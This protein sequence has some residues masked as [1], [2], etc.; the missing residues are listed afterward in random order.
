MDLRAAQ[1]HVPHPALRGWPPAGDTQRTQPLTPVR[2]THPGGRPRAGIRS[3]DGLQAIGHHFPHTLDLPGLAD[4]ISRS[5]SLATVPDSETTPSLVSTLMSM[6]GVASS[7]SRADFTLVVIQVS[8]TASPASSMVDSPAAS[9][10][11]LVRLSSAHAEAAPKPRAR[12][13][14]EAV[15]V[16]TFFMLFSPVY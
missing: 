8:E 10:S 15:N 2:G 5:A 6:P 4:A 14:A 16:G 9:S 1:W 3:V 13:S 12:A 7:T 11:G